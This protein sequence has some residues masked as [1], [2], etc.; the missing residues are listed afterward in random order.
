MKFE[1]EFSYNCVNCGA[2]N[3]AYFA[4][5]DNTIFGL[6]LNCMELVAESKCDKC[7]HWQVFETKLKALRFKKAKK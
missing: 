4:H 6:R 1:I 7:G 5:S 3:I 2:E